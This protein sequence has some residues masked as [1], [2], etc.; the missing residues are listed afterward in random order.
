MIEN[1]ERLAFGLWLARLDELRKSLKK[2][3]MPFPTVRSKLC[4]NFGL[5]WNIVKKYLHIMWESGMIEVSSCHGVKIAEYGEALLVY[6]EDPSEG[7]KFYEM[8]D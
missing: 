6:L 8:F 5:R 1:T 3:L 4:K 2:E 7:T